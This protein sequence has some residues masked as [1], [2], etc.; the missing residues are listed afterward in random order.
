MS[1]A[2]VE[3]LLGSQEPTHKL[4]IPPER[5]K[6]SYGAQTVA[7]CEMVGLHLDPGQL[8]LLIDGL[9]VRGRVAVS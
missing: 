4:V 2:L 5:V 8:Q 3:H 9:A 1:T 7:L 6:K